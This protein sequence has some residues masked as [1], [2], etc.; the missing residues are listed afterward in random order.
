MYTK[1]NMK[2]DKQ[3]M[4]KKKAIIMV[5]NSKTIKNIRNDQ[6]IGYQKTRNLAEIIMMNSQKSNNLIKK[7]KD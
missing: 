7:I 3:N 4:E 2:L 6:N 1:R 5:I